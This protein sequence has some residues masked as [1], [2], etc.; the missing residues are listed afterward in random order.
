[1]HFINKD[2]DK[3]SNE[4]QKWARKHHIGL[5]DEATYKAKINKFESDEKIYK[6]KIARSKIL[7]FFLI[8]DIYAY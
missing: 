4:E 6:R 7:V 3:L 8:L 5:Y 1:M 2:L